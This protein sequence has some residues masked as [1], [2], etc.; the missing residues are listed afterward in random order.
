MISGI[1]RS[2]LCDHGTRWNRRRRTA[3]ARPRSHPHFGTCRRVPARCGRPLA[4]MRPSGVPPGAAAKTGTPASPSPS[5]PSPGP[6]MRKAAWKRAAARPRRPPPHRPWAGGNAADAGIPLPAMA[7]WAP[8]PC[9]A[10]ACRLV[11]AV[12]ASVRAKG[13]GRFE[14][15]GRTG[16]RSPGRNRHPRTHA[17][18]GPLA[19]RATAAAAVSV[20]GG[21]RTA[22]AS[23]TVSGKGGARRWSRE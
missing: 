18:A 5:L 7:A 6:R 8:S 4:P 11:V 14:R 19:V 1:E 2:L 16:R 21:R 9:R 13:V 17:P 20:P 3:P 22:V 10:D 15:E 12:A 23:R